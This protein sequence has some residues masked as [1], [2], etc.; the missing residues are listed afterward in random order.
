MKLNPFT[1]KVS[2]RAKA[3]YPAGP[4]RDNGPIDTFVPSG[5][6]PVFPPVETPPWCKR[7]RNTRPVVILH[8]TLADQTSIS[9][10]RDLALEM[11]YPADLHTHVGIRDGAPMEESVQILSTRVNRDR[12]AV[13]REVLERLRDRQEGQELQDFFLLESDLYGEPD[14]A[15]AE[16]EE[17][18]PSLVERVGQILARPEKELLA[19]LSRRLDQLETDLAK[20]V[21]ATSFARGQDK[22]STLCA[23]VAAEL[24]DSLVPKAVVLGH[25]AGGFAAYTLALNPKKGLDDQ[26]PFAYD[27]GIG[28]SLGVVV[29]SPVG[30]GMENPAPPALLDLPFAQHDKTV[31]RPLESNPFHQTALFN[32]FYRAGYSNLKKMSQ[33]AWRN[34]MLT[35]TML[36]NPLIHALKPG[37]EQVMEGADFFEQY[38]AEKTLRPDLTV[39]SVTNPQDGIVPEQRAQLDDEQPNAHN[40]SVKVEIPDEE[41][42]KKLSL[43]TWAHFKMGQV[44]REVRAEFQR[45]VIENPKELP[46]ILHPCNHDGFRYLALKTL[47]ETIEKQPSLLRTDAYRNTCSAIKAVARERLPF[48]DSPSF[49][50]QQIVEAL[51][52]LFENR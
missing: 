36:N 10:F 15:V 5:V 16:I 38:V 45:T 49:L 30:R 44:P 8:G 52:D 17:F 42:E 4:G 6:E 51:P 14:S 12:L 22:R 26:N 20:Q 33:L 48:R 23:K 2:G 43:P 13:G 28:V 41:L 27:A 35:W 9:A 21:E 37:Y 24:V 40:L 32:P 18:L 11:G 29:S 46:K 50:A 19:S 7:A 34:G 31:L 3:A 47:Q 1:A 25:S 39:V